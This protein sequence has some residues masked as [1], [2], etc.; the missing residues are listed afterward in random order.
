MKNFNHKCHKQY[1]PNTVKIFHISVLAE[2]GEE[3]IA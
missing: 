1:I 3:L 2:G